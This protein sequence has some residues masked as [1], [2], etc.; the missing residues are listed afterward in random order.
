MSNKPLLGVKV[1][2]LATFIAAATA[3]RFLADLG[4]DVIKIESAKGDPLRYT[5]PS[6]G[7]PLDMYENTTWDLENAN[8]RCISLNM[9]TP[10]GK[11]TFFK[12]LDTADI[13]ITN[14]RPQALERA[15]LNYERLKEKYPR[16]VYAMCTGYGEYGPDKDLPGFDFTAY[17]ARGGYLE[18][19]RQK[20]SVPMNVVPGLGDHNVG[21]NLAAGILAALYQAKTKGVGEKVT[22]SL[23]QTAVFNMGMM[24]QAAQYKDIGTPYPINVREGNNP[25]LA[26]WE[27]KD[28][29]YIQTCTPDYNTYYKKLMAAIGRDDLIDSDKYFPIQNLQ[30]AEIGYEVYDIVMA[31]IRTMTVE[32]CS[33]RLTEADIPFALAQSWEEILEDKQAWANE[34]FYSMKYDNG[35][36]RTLVRPPV[37]F[38]EM[39]EPDYVRGPMIGEQGKEVLKEIGYTDEQI[40]KLI[41]DKSLYIG[42]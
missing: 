32:E 23:Y 2:E 14:W 4:A 29:R 12:L 33:K 40:N 31:A 9:K 21:I 30:K 41:E 26:A 28:G 22:T 34:C 19:L 13:L 11:E 27:T 10:E 42:E 5:A 36:T 1:I 37:N 39:G 25:L 35:N 24:I 18:T 7:R 15:E 17:F 3:G 20:G 6:E 38:A 8:K 16:L